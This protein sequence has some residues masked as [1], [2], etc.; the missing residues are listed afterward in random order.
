MTQQTRAPE[1]SLEDRALSGNERERSPLSALL[2][3]PT[4]RRVR[5]FFDNHVVADSIEVKL[6]L[7]KDHLPVY[8][9]PGQ[10]VNMKVL[11]PS[12]KKTHCPL[13]GE[14]S[15]WSISTG[16]RKAP[17]AAWSYPEPVA[18]A[19]ELAGYVAFYW[20]RVDAWFEEDDQVYVHPRDPYSRVDVLQSS[21][22][23]RFEIA[24]ETVAETDRPRL[25]FETGL[26]VRYYIP[27]LDVRMEFL[28]PSPTRTRCPYK[29]EASYW[30]VRAGGKVFDDLA[31]SYREPIP[32]CPKIENLI[33][34][35]NERVDT[36][37]DGQKT[38]TPRTHWSR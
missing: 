13:K 9:F 21:R 16:T 8:Y 34:F 2:I 20:D 17:E 15:Y 11:E 18:G 25:L 5:A 4:G 26:P 7:E 28:D 35:F 30:H 3:Q 38:E 1:G 24:G 19:Q 37:V 14:A 29:G 23:V 33:C 27:K 12:D 32:E 31:W 6:V 22:H 36:F 10:D